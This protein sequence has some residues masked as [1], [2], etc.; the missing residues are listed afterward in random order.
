MN[1]SIPHLQAQ[2]RGGN[3]TPT[4]LVKQLDA[5]IGEANSHNI[6]ISRLS[7]DE[8]LVCQKLGRQR[9]R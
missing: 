1:L 8:M 9:P 6:W 4:A 2:Y 3:L 5:E 7:L